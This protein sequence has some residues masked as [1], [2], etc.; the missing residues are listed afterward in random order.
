MSTYEAVRPLEPGK[1]VDVLERNEQGLLVGVWHGY[2]NYKR[3]TVALYPN[4]KNRFAFWPG[5]TLPGKRVVS[6]RVV[7]VRRAERAALPPPKQTKP[8][9]REGIS[10]GV[11]EKMKFE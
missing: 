10:G 9:P 4:P 5:G 7:N 6:D 8:A 3:G 11:Q 1:P 2:W